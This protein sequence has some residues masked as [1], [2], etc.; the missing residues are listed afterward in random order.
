MTLTSEQKKHLLI[1]SGVG[2]L[3]L[4]LGTTLFGRRSIAAASASAPSRHLPGQEHAPRK[5]K[6]RRHDDHG[7]DN[8]RG[9]YGGKKK[10]KHKLKDHHRGH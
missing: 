6:K 5:R 2:A 10:H 3:A 4:L 7:G 9:E 1:G 8:D